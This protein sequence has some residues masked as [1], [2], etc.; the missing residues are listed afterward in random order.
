MAVNGK[1]E[2]GPTNGGQL[3]DRLQISRTGA[4]APLLVLAGITLIAVLGFIQNQPPFLP[5]EG[6]LAAYPHSPIEFPNVF[7]KDVALDGLDGGG[8]DGGMVAVAG[9]PFSRGI[10][11]CMDCHGEKDL[12]P[13]P[14]RR[15]MV[16]KHQNIKLINHDEE[17]L[18]CLDCHDLN[19]RDSLHLA[20]GELVPFTE[21]YRLCGQCHGPQYKDW[22]VGIHGKRTGYWNGAK[23]YL[24]CVNCHNPH[25]P[26]FAPLKPLPP[27]VR[28]N[29]LR[30]SDRPPPIPEV[31]A[32]DG[33]GATP[34]EPKK[35]EC[36]GK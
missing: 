32:A 6:V 29:F 17:H 10:F 26:H 7:G 22:K 16:D 12:P 18:W 21:S 15:P 2:G 34:P 28:P 19:D 13:N 31:S 27:P 30:A 25:S 9:P 20:G 35:E 23:R 4:L 5:N 24:L 36:H 3:V 8:G 33:G 11:P 1:P 14:T